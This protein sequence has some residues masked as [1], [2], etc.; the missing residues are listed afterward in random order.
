MEY[1]QLSNTEKIACV[2]E[3]NFFRTERHDA[4][5]Y[6]NALRTDNRAIIEE[7]ESFGDRP[8][9]FFLNKRT[10]DAGLQFGFTG[11]RFNKYGWLENADFTAKEHIEFTPQ[12]RPVA[13]N[14]LTIGQGANGKWSYGASYSTGAAGCGYGLGVWGKVFDTRKECL[15]A[16]LQEIMDGHRRYEKDLKGDTCGNFNARLSREIVRQVKDMFDELTGR[17]A[18]QLSFF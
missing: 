2:R 10:Y 11:K 12:D 3:M 9:Q 5:V 17:K 16:A 4:A 6:L 13:S 8:Y 15:K 14:H 1:N 7:Y 18:V